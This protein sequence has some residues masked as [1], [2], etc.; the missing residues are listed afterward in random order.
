M[1]VLPAAER[2]LNEAEQ[3]YKEIDP[4]LGERFTQEAVSTLDL[5]VKSPKLF[6]YRRKP[7]RACQLASF[8]YLVYYIYEVERP[9]V[10]AVLH[11]KRSAREWWLR[12]KE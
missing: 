5:V 4:A 10:I 12:R 6:A 9:R 3:F 1:T 11:A 2:D 7:I 8:P